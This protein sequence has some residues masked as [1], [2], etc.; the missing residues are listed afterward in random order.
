MNTKKFAMTIALGTLMTGA[1]V[2]AM[3]ANMGFD[4]TGSQWLKQVANTPST[5]TRAEVKNQVL[6]ARQQGTLAISNT[7][8]PVTAASNATPRTRAAVRAE[9]IQSVQ[10][11]QTSDLYTGG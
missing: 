6:M 5:V 10:N 7:T 8:Y 2:G 9:A 3:A 11:G 1:S 4:E